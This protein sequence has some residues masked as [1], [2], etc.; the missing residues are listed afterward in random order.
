[1]RRFF[2]LGG[3]VRRRLS[4]LLLLL[5]IPSITAFVQSDKILCRVSLLAEATTLFPP[6]SQ[7]GIHRDYSFLCHVIW[8]FE[9]VDFNSVIFEPSHEVVEQHS[10]ELFE[11]DWFISFP[12]RWLTNERPTPTIEPPEG[13]QVTTLDLHSV[14][15][16]LQQSNLRPPSTSSI[17]RR[18]RQTRETTSNEKVLVVL[19]S[20]PDASPYQLSKTEAMDIMFSN[21]D[22]SVAGQF[23]ACS[24]GSMGIEKFGDGVLEVTVNAP[25]NTLDKY[26][27]LYQAESKVCQYYNLNS[28]CDPAYEK[29]IDHIAYVVPFGLS[30]D[31]SPNGFA[32]A[33]VGSTYSIFQG[34]AF[35]TATILHE[36]GHNY[37]L[38]H[39]GQGVSEYGDN[40]GQMG[41]SKQQN[42]VYDPMVRRGSLYSKSNVV[43]T[44]YFGTSIPVTKRCFN[45]WNMWELG[46]HKEHR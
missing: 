25:I 28:L 16:H 17:S 24:F 2:S 29:D 15:R 9:K 37:Y 26:A 30:S 10:H 45:G 3:H 34:K 32:S 6:P 33:G 1:M 13:Q 40:T 14:Q 22:S 44:S 8:S 46:W 31:A 12:V 35:T 5:Y 18:R 41:K 7:S 23:N 38:G 4:L 20:T 21:D 43:G 19:V 42:C 11:E 27:I 36:F 39:A